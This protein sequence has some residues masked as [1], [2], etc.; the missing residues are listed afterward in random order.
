[1]L[2]WTGGTR[3]KSKLRPSSR[4]SVTLEPVKTFSGMR[5]PPSC[6]VTVEPARPDLGSLLHPANDQDI[7]RANGSTRNGRIPPPEVL[8]AY[9]V[10][11]GNR[12]ERVPAS[13]PVPLC[14][15][16]G[17]TRSL[18]ADLEVFSRAFRQIDEERPR[19]K[20]APR[21]RRIE[22]LDLPVERA[23]PLGDPHDCQ[24]VADPHLHP[25]PRGRPV[26]L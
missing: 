20:R 25:V 15:G 26:Q 17:D 19:R 6:G 14:R 22:K 21:D 1:M 3:T 16:G 4:S 12:G 13:H 11:S 18:L 7:T 23:C 10:L 24:V 9:P 8:Q 5:G 2:A